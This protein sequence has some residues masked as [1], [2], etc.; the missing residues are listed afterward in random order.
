M[1]TPPRTHPRSQAGESVPLSKFSDKK[2]LL[3]VNVAYA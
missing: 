3:V 2:A 1:S